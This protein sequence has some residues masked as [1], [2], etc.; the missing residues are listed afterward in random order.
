[1]HIYI[2]IYI[3]NNNNNTN[4]DNKHND[5]NNDN[6]TNNDN[7]NANNNNSNN[8]NNNNNDNNDNHDIRGGRAFLSAPRAWGSPS[9]SFNRT[10]DLPTKIVPA[11]LRFADSKFP[12]N[13]P[14]TR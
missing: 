8:N 10:P 11:V 9:I 3:Y 6:N 2:Y 4:N 14:W 7:D 1:M 13:S 5:N 12:A